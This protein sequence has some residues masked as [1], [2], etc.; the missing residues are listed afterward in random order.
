MEFRGKTAAIIGG[1]G[2]IGREL[3]L[4]LAEQ[5]ATVVVGDIDESAANE[6]AN[7]AREKKQSIL[8]TKC[9]IGE[10][11]SVLSFADFAFEEL[12]KVD[13]LFNHAGVSVG[14]L[15]EQ[16]S[17]DDWN[18]LLNINLTG[19]GRSVSAFVPRMAAQGGGWITNTSSGLGLF[20]DMP[21]A[22]PYI[23]TK[24][25]IIAYS[26]ALATYTRNRGIGVSVFCPDATM[27][28]FMTSG[29]I[30][31]I[32]KEILAAGVPADKI[33]TAGQAVDTLLEGL[34]AEQF[35]ISA[36]PGTS[37]KLLAMAKADLEPG[38]DEF[39]ARGV[40]DMVISKGGLRVP[41]EAQGEALDLFREFAAVTQRHYGC[42]F[43]DIAISA[44]DP[45]Q[46]VIFEVWDSKAALDAHAAA[47]GA[48]DLIMK[49]FALGAT[50]F[51]VQD[52]H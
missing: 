27:T 24:A 26:R 22:G 5:G 19:L 31:G 9:D 34:K 13:L 43:Y 2:G 6:T 35:L 48:M 46:L 40:P 28:N 10:D 20:H 3:A 29:R 23:S 15:L 32:P 4:A 47:P 45:E 25:G 51:G 41:L 8:A 1:G 7:L 36:V 21:F 30:T 42:R 18:W 44:S 49:L 50:D 39:D 33:Q 52:I 17:S 38:S 11:A 37:A 16:I 12:G 14:G